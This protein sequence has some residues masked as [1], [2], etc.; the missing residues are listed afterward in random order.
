MHFSEEVLFVVAFLAALVP[1]AEVQG[2]LLPVRQR[3]PVM[4]V[5]VAGLRSVARGL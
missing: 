4:A 5:V 2:L 3:V 1:L